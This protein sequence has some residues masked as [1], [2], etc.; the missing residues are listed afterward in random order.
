MKSTTFTRT[1]CFLMVLAVI[2]LFTVGTLVIIHI[3]TNWLIETLSLSSTPYEQNQH[4]Y[5]LLLSLQETSGTARV[6]DVFDFDFDEA[7]VVSTS[8]GD[9][10]YYLE[11]FGVTTAV[12]IYSW[13][14]GGHYRI[15]FVKDKCI[16]YDF[17]YNIKKIDT[18]EKGMT[19]Y[20]DTIMHLTEE[21]YGDSDS[22][23]LI[24]FE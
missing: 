17:V 16:I 22:Y 8:Y 23:V 12:P 7:Y 20:P 3:S 24:T 18:H 15:F 13:E 21:F 1:L 9:E 14:T 19:I 6:G 11:V 10:A 2:I 4:Y 5:D